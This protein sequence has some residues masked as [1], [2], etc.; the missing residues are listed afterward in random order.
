MHGA[1]PRRTRAFTLIEMI[2]AIGA[3]ALIAVGI[4][5]VFESVGRTVGG[6]R[7][8]SVLNQYAA[9]ME[10]QMRADFEA[11][12][13]DGV[14]VIRHEYAD[15]NG[16]SQITEPEDHVP[17]YQDQAANPWPNRR[18]DWRLRRLDQI[19]FFARGEFS[20]SRAPV[21]PGVTAESSEAMI[22]YGHGLRLDPID[23]FQSHAPGASEPAYEMPQVDDGRP[24][25]PTGNDRL[26]RDTAALGYD[27]GDPAT[28][29]PNLHAS[30][31][32]LL[33]QMI[34]LAP[35]GSTQSLPP[36][37]PFWG[38]LDF[39]RDDALDN[40]IQIGGQPAASSAF[41]TLA[42]RFP[43]YYGYPATIRAVANDSPRYPA[44]ASGIV[45]VATTD[46]AEIRRIVMD[47]NLFPDNINTELD[48]FDPSNAASTPLDD[49]YSRTG[50]PG[51][52]VR[53]MQAWMDDLLPADPETGL[54]P[55]YELSLPDYYGAVTNSTGD[56][57]PSLRLADQR[58]LGSG[59][60]VPNCTEFIVEYSFGQVLAGGPFAGQLVWFG[61][62]RDIIIDGQ[63]PRPAVRP[64]PDA[65]DPEDGDEVEMWYEPTYTKLD[66]TKS[67]PQKL[68][69]ATLYSVLGS[70]GGG[71]G[72]GGS[73][74]LPLTA[75]FGYNDPTYAPTD[76]NLDPPTIPWPWPKLIRITVTL[77][78]P[79][80][81]SIEETFQFVFE[82]PD[83][84]VF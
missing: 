55:R 61:R 44:F 11:M 57:E 16:D 60:F 48:L 42:A 10:R 62:D 28:R 83:G 25:S 14:L 18:A 67:P 9:L 20:S 75:H 64:Y 51:N 56:L 13:R 4:A 22:Y 54:R 29:N 36:P 39:D 19:L 49:R 41:R 69:T 43:S 82:T 15:V 34:L 6:G 31:W 46:L 8:V 27:D 78:D 65:V 38:D 3:V 76:P 37:G 52:P 68:T 74:S 53:F 73:P 32:T 58:A 50:G 12:T 7:R 5:A 33:R 77:A 79:T 30:G 66:G 81:P 70:A 71:G 35:P 17:L 72:G 24:E 63:P 45:D 1:E 80:D 40:D 2:V 26:Y 59:V 23:D 21:I 47:A 84:R